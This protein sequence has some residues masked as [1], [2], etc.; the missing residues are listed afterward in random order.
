MLQFLRANITKRQLVKDLELLV[1]SL[2]WDSVKCS[3]DVVLFDHLVRSYTSIK[4]NLLRDYITVPEAL[5]LLV[6]AQAGY[7]NSP[8]VGNYENLRMYNDVW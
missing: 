6:Q 3:D 2:N 4:E 1:L 7:V 5:N 8:S